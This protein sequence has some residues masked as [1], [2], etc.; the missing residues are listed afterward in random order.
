RFFAETILTV[1]KKNPQLAARLLTA[2]RSWR[3]FEAVRREHA[4]EA[5]ASIAVV[6]DLS[7]DVSDIV[8]RTLA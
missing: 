5:L 8:Q 4:R 2:M 1:D 7:A 6:K 3:S